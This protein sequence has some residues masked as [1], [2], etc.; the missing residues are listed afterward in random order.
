MNQNEAAE[1]PEATEAE[2]VGL[3]HFGSSGKTSEI[4]L[5]AESLTFLGRL[6]R[7]PFTGVWACNDRDSVRSLRPF[8][9]R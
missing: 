2:G 8:I 7:D 6:Y 1:A 3:V 5:T 4:R 9:I